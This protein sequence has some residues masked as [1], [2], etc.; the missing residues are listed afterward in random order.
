MPFIATSLRRPIRAIP[1]VTVAPLT[2]AYHLR[3]HPIALAISCPMSGKSS[4]IP[5]DVP[6]LFWYKCAC[7]IGLVHWT[8]VGDDAA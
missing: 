7:P 8:Y 2:Q 5:H 1:S 6:T 3:S 4:C